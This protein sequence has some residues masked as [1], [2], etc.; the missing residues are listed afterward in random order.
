MAANEEFDLTDLT[1]RV[2]RL[3]ADLKMADRVNG[4]L[5]RLMK[6]VLVAWHGW[7]WDFPED[8]GFTALKAAVEEME[9]AFND[10][11]DRARQLQDSCDS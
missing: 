9:E 3:Q 2:G 8:A 11:E 5:I 4:K 10:A 6:A 1:D 7:E